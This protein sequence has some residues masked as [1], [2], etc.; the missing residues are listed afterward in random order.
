M[1]TV[2]LKIDTG[3]TKKTVT[4]GDDYKDLNEKLR[5]ELFQYRVEIQ[6]YKRSI[7]MLC[8]C[9][10][11][12]V[13]ILGYFG[14]DRVDVIVERV[15]QKA[16]ARLAKTDELLAKIDTRY[17]DS[18]QSTVEERSRA[19]EAAISALEKGTRVNDELY[20]KLISGLPYNKR[21]EGGV[22]G[23][24][25]SLATNIFDLVYYTPDYSYGK[26]GECYIIMSDEYTYDKS[27]VF[28]VAVF[29]KNRRLA[30]YHQAFVVHENYN[31][32]HFSF[33]RYENYDE[34]TLEIVLLQKNKK[35]TIGYTLSTPM[36]IK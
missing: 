27:D 11:V 28:L 18:L 32:L 30:V 1:I 12:V 21:V 5:D 17:L 33:D 36:R 3:M 25:K 19:Y 4:N 23:Y 15:E 9:V 13:A 6:S 20:K 22:A 10:S 24:V 29:P 8:V 16:N 31:K 2:F 34:Y 26:T 35:E 14:Y 7:R